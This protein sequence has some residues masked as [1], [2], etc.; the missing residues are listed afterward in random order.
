MSIPYLSKQQ[1]NSAQLPTG[2]TSPLIQ[3]DD[4][5]VSSHI[6]IQLKHSH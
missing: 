1:I 6:Q 3:L 2:L 5:S 4:A